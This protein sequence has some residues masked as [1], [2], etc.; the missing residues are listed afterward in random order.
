MTEGQKICS[1]CMRKD[2][3]LTEILFFRN[4]QDWMQSTNPLEITAVNLADQCEHLPSKTRR[5][6]KKQVMIGEF[7]AT[8][9]WLFC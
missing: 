2:R 7:A 1:T 5:V 3:V 8:I 6:P 9:G 4:L